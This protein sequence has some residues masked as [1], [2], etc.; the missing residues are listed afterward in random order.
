MTSV[1]SIRT[2][3]YA[4]NPDAISLIDFGKPGSTSVIV[5]VGPN[6]IVLE[7]ADAQVVRDAV[8]EYEPV[9]EAPA[10]EP[11]AAQI[12][13]VKAQAQAMTAAKPV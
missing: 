5:H 9:A 8:P 6:S 1:N 12:A 13:D 3:R 10:K 11:S 7:G 4:F 2:A